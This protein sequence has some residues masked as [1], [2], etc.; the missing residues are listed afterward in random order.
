MELDDHVT[1]GS[2]HILGIEN[3]GWKFVACHQHGF[4]SNVAHRKAQF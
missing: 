4:Q 3:N 1:I 2:G